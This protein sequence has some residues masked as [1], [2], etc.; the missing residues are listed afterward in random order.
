MGY[1]YADCKYIDRAAANWKEKLE[2]LWHLH[3][4]LHLER[5]Q[6]SRRL[7]MVGYQKVITAR[8]LKMS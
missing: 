1:N 4:S 8:R 7:W 6:R 5:K 2:Q 3:A